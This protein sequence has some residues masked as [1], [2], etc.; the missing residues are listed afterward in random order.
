MEIKSYLLKDKLK[1]P[2]RLSQIDVARIRKS[3]N[4]NTE[5]DF[6]EFMGCSIEYAK[7]IIH[8]WEIAQIELWDAEILKNFF[9]VA[10]YENR[11]FVAAR[12]S[13]ARHSGRLPERFTPREGL[14]WLESES[15]MMGMIPQWVKANVRP[16]T[17]TSVEQPQRNPQVTTAQPADTATVPVVEAP[18]SEPHPVTTVDVA[19]AFADIKWS[20]NKWLKPL[21]DKPK[22]LEVCIAIP[23]VRGVSE[24]RW[25]PVFIGAALVESGHAKPNSIRARFQTKPQLAEWLDAWKTYEADNLD[26]I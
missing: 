1:S 3:A 22:W 26:T 15:V 12:I 10:I 19:H 2:D 8:F 25:N 4:D 9:H 5:Q 23:G 6:Q 17:L 11:D 7:R 24:T 13:A 16:R 14:E 20:E 21:G 18:A